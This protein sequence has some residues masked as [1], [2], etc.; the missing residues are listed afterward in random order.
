MKV[1]FKK[2]KMFSD[3]KLI[4][5]LIAMKV[6]I[7]A[8]FDMNESQEML[9]SEESL[10]INKE[11]CIHGCPR[12]LDP[13]C[14]VDELHPQDYKYF[15]NQC[16]MEYDNCRQSRGKFFMGLLYNLFNQRIQKS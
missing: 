14:A 1:K 3:N 10:D 9:E 13:I 11:N 6:L 5:I 15:H 4:F 12:I 2:T 8:G 7:V 16:L